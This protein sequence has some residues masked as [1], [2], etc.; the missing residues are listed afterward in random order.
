MEALGERF[1][2]PLGRAVFTL[3]RKDKE[4]SILSAVRGFV[5][6]DGFERTCGAHG[7]KENTA[8][9]RTASLSSETFLDAL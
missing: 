5:E 7:E 9:Q 8:R 6:V 3:D 4:A 1:P 2:R